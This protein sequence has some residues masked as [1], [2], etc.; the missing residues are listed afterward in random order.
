MKRAKL[1]HRKAKRQQDAKARQEAYNKLSFEQKLAQA[2]TKQK[3]K[4]LAKLGK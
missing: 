3:A 2:G 1:A 4:L